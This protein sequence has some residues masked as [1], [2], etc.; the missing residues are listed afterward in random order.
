[1]T[2]ALSDTLRAWGDADFDRTLKQELCALPSGTLPLAMGTS[3]GGYV[4]D[5]NI[6]VTVLSANDDAR[7][8]QA[9][10]GIL[11]TEVV[12]SCSCGDEPLEA[13]AYCVV[14][15]RIDKATAEATFAAVPDLPG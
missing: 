4:D 13:N 5:G 15:I 3:Q 12:P 6:A 1:M 14:Q 10:V 11:F 7:S 2:A 8:V 9:R